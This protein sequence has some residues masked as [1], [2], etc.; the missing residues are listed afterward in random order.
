MILVD[1]DA[2]AA[3][4]NPALILPV[5]VNMGVPEV[6]D[7]QFDTPATRLPIIFILGLPATSNTGPGFVPVLDDISPL[8]SIVGLLVI[9][10]VPK[11]SPAV[12]HSTFPS[13]FNEPDDAAN[14]ALLV[15]G[16]PPI[17]H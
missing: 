3:A 9:C 15:V 6:I 14:I 17:P 2:I 10:I 8:M 12:P 4:L 5:M 1:V 16:E 13:I 11:L 7:M